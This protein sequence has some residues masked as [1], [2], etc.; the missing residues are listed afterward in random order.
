MSRL[1]GR[2]TVQRGQTLQLAL[3]EAADPDR[4][5]MVA[6][7]DIAP[8]HIFEARDVDRSDRK[9][10]E[11]E[12]TFGGK[13]YRITIKP[14]QIKNEADGTI[15]DRYLGERE[16]IVEE[17]IRRLAANRGRLT[18]HDGIKVRFLFKISEIRDEL[19]RVKHTYSLNE[20][21]EAIVLLNE[22]RMVIQDLDSKGSPMLSAPAFPVMGM[23]RRGEDRESFVEFNPLVAD[24]IRLLSFQQVDYE[25]LMDIRDP[26]A[27]WLLKRLHIEI[28]ASRQ[29]VQEITATDIRHNSGMPEWKTTRNLLRRIAQAVDVLVK[30]GVLDGVDT[31]SIMEGQRKV[32]TVFTVSASPSFM[33]QVHASNRVAREKLESFR[34][35]N[36]GI[37]PGEDFIPIGHADLFRLR[38][39]LRPPEGDVDPI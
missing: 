23:K 6:L 29:A 16:Q 1:E 38:A 32:D 4:S 9:I 10:I 21:K 5:N 30:K 15:S 3:W 33:T 28:A 14:T 13:Q 35:L 7:Y 37:A 34:R 8:R 19:Q 17:V 31:D 27:R 36:Q 12:F 11:R 22:V 25:M 2:R 20:I 18:L 39:A 26:V 24:A